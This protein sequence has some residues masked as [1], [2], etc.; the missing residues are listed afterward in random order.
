MRFMARKNK[1]CP[2]CSSFSQ[3]VSFQGGGVKTLRNWF[4]FILFFFLLTALFSLGLRGEQTKSR[5]L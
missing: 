4:Y 5:S 3:V 2:S 1:S